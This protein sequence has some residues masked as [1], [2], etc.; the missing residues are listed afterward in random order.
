[1]AILISNYIL[2]WRAFM[3]SKNIH[4]NKIKIQ[5]LFNNSADLVLYE[6]Q[7]LE[8]DKALVVYINGLIDKEA[9]NKHIL[10]PIMKELTSKTDIKSI[11]SISGIE[12][13]NNIDDIILA[14]TA[15][16]VVLFHEGL[17]ICYLLNLCDYEKRA[18]EESQNEQVLKGPKEAFIE[19]INVNKTLI[20]RK[21]RC[22]S[23]HKL[24]RRIY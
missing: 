7:T 13:T 15:G 24:Y 17:K 5:E 19:D 23:F 8:D 11:L 20:R 14:I 18:V 21:I 12:E 16:N 4:K 6:F 10:K 3:I 1:M 2:E 9:L 22:H